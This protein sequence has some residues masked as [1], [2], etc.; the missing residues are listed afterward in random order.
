MKKEIK[1]CFDGYDF[2]YEVEEKKVI[3]MVTDEVIYNYFKGI[4]I[5]EELRQAF[6]KF[7]DYADVISLYEY[8]IKEWFESDAYSE[9]K[10]G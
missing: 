5:T 8:E 10:R 9:F 6:E 1:Y 2:T 3:K 4:E 7:I